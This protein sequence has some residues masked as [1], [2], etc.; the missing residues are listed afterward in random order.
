MRYAQELQ[1]EFKKFQN[2]YQ[3][4]L[5]RI[6]IDI[7][8]FKAAIDNLTKAAEDFHTRLDKIS[9]KE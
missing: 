2:I 4:D 6:N 1:H 3:N 7:T 5:D 9:K 8:N